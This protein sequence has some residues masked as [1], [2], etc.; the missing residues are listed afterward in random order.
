MSHIDGLSISIFERSLSG[1]VQVSL[2]SV[3]AAEA[4]VWLE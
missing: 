3:A 2:I 4:N 1:I